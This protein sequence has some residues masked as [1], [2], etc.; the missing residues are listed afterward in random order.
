MSVDL[1]DGRSIILPV[2]F[3][4]AGM[5]TYGAGD[6]AEYVDAWCQ[7]GAESFDLENGYD[8]QRIRRHVESG[9]LS[10]DDALAILDNIEQEVRA[11]WASIEK[12]RADWST[13]QEHIMELWKNAGAGL[14][15][16]NA[17]ADSLDRIG[18]IIEDQVGSV[19]I[20]DV[21][22]IMGITD[23]IASVRAMT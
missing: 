15:E 11:A 10:R 17:V 1:G 7:F 21:L 23:E 20:T 18:A 5:G 19:S 6:L 14:H 13:H 12:F 3:A 8:L 16:L 9:L 4:W 22:Q 2:D